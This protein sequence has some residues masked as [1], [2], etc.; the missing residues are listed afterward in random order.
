[1]DSEYRR[2]ST[3]NIPT[4][5]SRTAHILVAWYAIFQLGH[6]FFNAIYLMNPGVPPFHP[7]PDGWNPQTV[8]FLN[9]M[10]FSDWINSALTLVF[11][12]GFFRQKHWNAWLGTLCLTVSVYAAIVFVWGAE[13]SGAEGLGMPYFWINMPFIPV[14]LLFLLWCYW[15]ATSQLTQTKTGDT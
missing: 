3:L 2:L 4:P 10:A 11:A 1:M 9:G 12:W 15:G 14:V 8:H 7:P 5:A 6:F 13:A